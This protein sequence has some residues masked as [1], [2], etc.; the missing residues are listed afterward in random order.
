MKI[1]YILLLFMKLSTNMNDY[2]KPPIILLSPYK[3][4]LR[5]ERLRKIKS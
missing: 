3:H 1:S 4:T 2:L 5:E